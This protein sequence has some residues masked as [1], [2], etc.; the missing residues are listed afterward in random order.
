V[1]QTLSAVE[2]GVT[3]ERSCN[4]TVAE[5][6]RNG[7]RN[8]TSAGF[9]EDSA[10]PSDLSKA[11]VRNIMVTCS[12]ASRFYFKEGDAGVQEEFSIAAAVFLALRGEIFVACKNVPSGRGLF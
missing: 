9:A 4:V 10:D 3:S 6:A 11:V 2:Y 1:T 12:A 8:W 5:S 7:A